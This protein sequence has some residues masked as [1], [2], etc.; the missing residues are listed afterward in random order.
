[1]K[2]SKHKLVKNKKI[3]DFSKESKNCRSR[4]VLSFKGAKY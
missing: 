4:K 1:M 2:R 3:I